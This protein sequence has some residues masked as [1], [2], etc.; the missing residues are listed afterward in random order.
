MKRSRAELTHIFKHVQGKKNETFNKGENLTFHFKIS[1][2]QFVVLLSSSAL[3][4]TCLQCSSIMSDKDQTKVPTAIQPTEDFGPAGK[5][6]FT[7]IGDTGLPMNLSS[8]KRDCSSNSGGTNNGCC[9]LAY[10]IK[11]MI[12]SS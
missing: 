10:S 4:E 5:N 9:S 6:C 1:F 11:S 2:F 12:E 8:M 7:P 3:A